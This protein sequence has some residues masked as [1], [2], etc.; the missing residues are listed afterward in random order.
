MIFCSRFGAIYETFSV[1]TLYTKPFAVWGGEVIYEMSRYN[2]FWMSRNVVVSFAD[3]IATIWNIVYDQNS[4]GLR[5]ELTHR[6]YGSGVEDWHAESKLFSAD[7]SPRRRRSA[8]FPATPQFSPWESA[9][10]AVWP[11][12]FLPKTAY[13]SLTYFDFSNPKM[14]GYTPGVH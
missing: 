10:G 11:R 2:F 9:A 4:S 13:N 7:I 6:L 14:R 1:W 12:T 3:A 8:A 5:E